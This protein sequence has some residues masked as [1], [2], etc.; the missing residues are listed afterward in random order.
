MNRRG[1]KKPGG[2]I[3]HAREN[4]VPVLLLWSSRLV[5]AQAEE[6]VVQPGHRARELVGRVV[7]HHR[8][9]EHVARCRDGDHSGEARPG[10]ATCLDARE[11]AT[12]RETEP[13]ASTCPDEN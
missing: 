4:H 13:T 6:S 8:P 3:V 2:G 11:A 7:H 9:L 5:G 1:S 10:V 12:R